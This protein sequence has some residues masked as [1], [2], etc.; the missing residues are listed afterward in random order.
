M[1]WTGEFTQRTFKEVFNEEVVR[2]F[3]VLRMVEIKKNP[4]P[5]EKEVS[6][7]YA[8][9]QPNGKQYVVGLVV[10]MKSYL[11]QGKR[12]VLWKEMDESVGP[13]YYGCPKNIL[14]MLSPIESIE[15]AG[16]AK[17]WR[18]KCLRYNKGLSSNI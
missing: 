3:D 15:H 2:G 10:I 16:Y 1:G 18:E 4:M 12:E 13:N 6:E 17:E 8:A 14:D 7:F 5:D 11:D 9:I